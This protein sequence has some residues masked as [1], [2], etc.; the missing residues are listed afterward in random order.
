MIVGDARDLASFADESVHLV[1]TSPPYWT[2]K[3]YNE[4]DGQLGH[5]ANYE[6]FLDQLDLVWSEVYRM[7]VP[8]GRLIVVVGDVA[9]LAGRTTVVTRSCRYMPRSKSIVG[10]SASMA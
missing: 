4:R 2:L 6:T 1:V 7:L 8:G 10:G 3:K 5:W 9:C